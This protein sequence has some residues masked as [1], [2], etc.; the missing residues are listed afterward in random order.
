M[1]LSFSSCDLNARFGVRAGQ[2]KGRELLRRLIREI[3]VGTTISKD[4][5]APYTHAHTQH[6]TPFISLPPSLSF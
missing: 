1:R 6:T 3:H 4:G 5:N 2:K